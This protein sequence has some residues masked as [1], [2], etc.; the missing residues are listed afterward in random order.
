M[1]V[2]LPLPKPEDEEVKRLFSRFV[3]DGSVSAL[4]LFGLPD[5]DARGAL[6]HC[7][8]KLAIFGV[9]RV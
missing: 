8:G 7:Q 6:A 9:F 1:L 5:K 3:N 2:S 4:E